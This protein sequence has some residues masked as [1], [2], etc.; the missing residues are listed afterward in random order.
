MQRDWWSMYLKCVLFPIHNKHTFF[1]IS[2]FEGTG[3]VTVNIFTLHAM[4]NV[5]H[6]E[7][8]IHP[9]LKDQMSSTKRYIKNGCNFDTWKEKPG[10]ALF[11]Y[12][13][14]VREYGWESYRN[15]L[16]TYEKSKPKLRSEQEKMDHW[17]LTFS[18]EVGYN[19][20]P[21]FKFWGF[22]VSQS[23]I[24]DLED[25]P[26]PNIGDEFIELAPERYCI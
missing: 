22:P 5:C 17:I 12:A 8:W 4:D 1:H 23:I 21:L 20:V 6:I 9:W 25:Y 13:Q 2:A 19:L 18:K 26:I 14:L 16:R 7:T 24:D 15:V 3:E 11:I 10:V